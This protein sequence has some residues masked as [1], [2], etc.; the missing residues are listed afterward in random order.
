MSPS[1][2]ARSAFSETGGAGEPAL[3]DRDPCSPLPPVQRADPKEP[4]L[5]ATGAFDPKAAFCASRPFIRPTLK[6]SS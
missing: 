6:G 3:F 2:R 5:G 1:W 4:A